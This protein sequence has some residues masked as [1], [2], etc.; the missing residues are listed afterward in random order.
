MYIVI[1]NPVSWVMCCLYELSF[2]FLPFFVM[3]GNTTYKA[4]TFFFVC[5]CVFLIFFYKNYVRKGPDV[6]FSGNM[7]SLRHTHKTFN[8]LLSSKSIGK[9][10]ALIKLC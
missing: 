9:Y 4:C 10:F 7:Y 2:Y 6:T 1:V 3:F 8:V 5:F